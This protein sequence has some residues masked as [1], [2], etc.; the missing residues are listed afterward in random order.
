MKTSIL[1]SSV[2]ASIASLVSATPAQPTQL[3]SVDSNGVQSNGGS[4]Y[5]SISGDGRYVAFESLGSNLVAND[6]NG[7][8]DVF[9]RDMLTGVTTRVSTDVAGVEGD[10]ES[11]DAAISPDGRY[12]AFESVATNLVAGDTN[13]K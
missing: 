9:V 13:G 5:P 11:T 4:R 12:V 10:G 2:A 6:T 7:V 1:L 3:V 8:R